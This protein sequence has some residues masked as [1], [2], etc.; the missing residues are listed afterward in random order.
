MMAGNSRL[1]LRL[2]CIGLET[3]GSV[4]GTKVGHILV[5]CTRKA[6]E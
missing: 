6:R 4:I 3:H 1:R 5:G 2:S